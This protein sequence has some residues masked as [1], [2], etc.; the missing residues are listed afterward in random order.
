MLKQRREVPVT[1]SYH[2]KETNAMLKHEKS[3]RHDKTKEAPVILKHKKEA[4]VMLKQKEEAQ[5]KGTSPRK[6][7]IKKPA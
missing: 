5:T 4:R 6:A 2:R 3:S 7:K 1:P